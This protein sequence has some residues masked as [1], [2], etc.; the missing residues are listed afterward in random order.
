MAADRPLVVFTPSGKRGRFAEGTTLLQAARTLGVDLDS[1]CGGRGLC[2]RCQIRIAEG[3]FAKHAIRSEQGHVSASGEVEAR[4]R[5][6]K[7]MAES[8]RLSCQARILGDV[9]VDVPAES[10]VH[11]QVVR[12][13]A[14]VRAI[15]LD[16]VVRLHYVEVA[17]PDMHAQRGDLE[18]LQEALAAQWQI[19]ALTCDLAVLQGLQ[20]ALRE[21]EWKVTVAIEAGAAPDRHLA[22]L[23][24]PRLRPRDRRRLDHDRRPSVRSAQRRGAGLGRPDEPA[25]PLRR[26][27][28]EPGLLCD[29]EPGRGRPR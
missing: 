6:R 29:D 11:R 14:E 27:S 7:G 15:A 26:G 2:G 19:G 13:R 28:D 22:G 16:P 1:V 24:R 21:G 25:D 12:K 9:V 8:H 4:Y 5:A 23:R 3:E 18:R 10:Q 20:P 17:P